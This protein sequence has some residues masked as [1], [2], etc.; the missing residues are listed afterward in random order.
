[1]NSKYT[2]L[3]LALLLATF[4]YAVNFKLKS[5]KLK[6]LYFT[7]STE[8]TYT[9]G[10]VKSKLF[11]LKQTNDFTLNTIYFNALQTITAPPKTFGY[12]DNIKVDK[13]I[14]FIRLKGV[15]VGTVFGNDISTLKLVIVD[16]LLNKNLPAT[17]KVKESKF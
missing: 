4:T 2:Y 8:L 16:K 6:P 5:P 9:N 17:V 3:I 10:A 14:K 1:M 11:I 7:S 15:T 12:I 13:G